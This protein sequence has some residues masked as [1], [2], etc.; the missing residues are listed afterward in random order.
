MRWWLAGTF[1]LIAALT[2]IAVTLISAQRTDR[3]LRSRAQDFAVGNATLAAEAVSNGLKHR[4]CRRPCTR[5]NA[6]AV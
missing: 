5:S 6:T 1:A 3:A 2:A 4:T